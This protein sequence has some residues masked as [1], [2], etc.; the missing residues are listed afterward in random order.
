MADK[1]AVLL[2]TPEIGRLPEDMGTLARFIS[3]KSGVRGEV[4]AALCEGLRERGINCHLGTLNLKKRF[5]EECGLNEED[6]RNIRYK[7]DPDRIHLVNASFISNLL[8]AY[9]GAPL[10][11]AAEF[12]RQMVNH[13]IKIVRAK[14]GGRRHHRLCQGDGVPGAAYHS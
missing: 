10:L 5:K 11:N 1:T 12:Q 4:V 2:L 7:I 3:G 6:W 13:I 14:S 9:S 8:S